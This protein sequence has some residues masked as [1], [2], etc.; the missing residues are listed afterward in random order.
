MA[1]KKGRESSFPSYYY[2]FGE[3]P[4]SILTVF[5]I[6][7]PTQLAGDPEVLIIRTARPS[8]WYRMSKYVTQPSA[9][10][11][12]AHDKIVAQPINLSI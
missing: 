2:L 5:L 8:G 9:I 1:Q 7:I 6:G 11:T 3:P 4:P 12:W 10:Q